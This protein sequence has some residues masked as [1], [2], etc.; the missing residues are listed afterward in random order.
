MVVDGGATVEVAVV[1]VW[2]YFFY[3]FQFPLLLR[4][5]DLEFVGVVGVVDRR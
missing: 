3:F 4:F 5:L 2:F 1:M